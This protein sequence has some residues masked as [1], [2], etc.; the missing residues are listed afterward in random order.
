MGV[1][2]GLLRINV[3]LEDVQDLTEDLDAALKAAGI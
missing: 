2:D 3:G 1:T